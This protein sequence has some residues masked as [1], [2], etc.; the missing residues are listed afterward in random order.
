MQDLDKIIIEGVRYCLWIFPLDT[1]WTMWNPK[2]KIRLLRT[3]CWRGYIATWE[4]TDN[5][6]Y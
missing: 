2:S 6:L 5:V 1:Y 4:I 3:S